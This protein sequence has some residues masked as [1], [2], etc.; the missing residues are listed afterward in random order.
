M[1][2]ELLTRLEIEWWSDYASH[3]YC[4]PFRDWVLW[5]YR[6]TLIRPPSDNAIFDFKFSTD[7]DLDNFL[8]KWL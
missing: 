8:N 1:P 6:A 2:L 7:E 3:T 5:K 4:Y